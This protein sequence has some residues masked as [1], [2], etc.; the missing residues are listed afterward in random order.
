MPGFYHLSVKIGSRSKGTSAVA[1]AAYR[2]GTKIINLQTGEIADYTRKTGVV[3]SEILI[4]KHA[5]RE[6]FNREILWSAVEKVEERVNSQLFRE[7]TIAFPRELTDEQQ[8]D[9]IRQ[10]AEH[11]VAEG[12]C[13]DFSIHNPDSKNH[14]PHAHMMCTLRKILSDGT[15]A[16]EKTKTQPMYEK[17]KDGNRIP[18]IDEETGKQKIKII[19]NEEHLQWKKVPDIDPKT[20]KQKLRKRKGKG[21][22][23]VWKY[24]TIVYND[25]DFRDKVEEWRKDWADIC[26]EVLDEEHSID[27]RSFA[28]QGI[29]YRIPTIHEGYAARE[30]E[31]KGGIS[32]R[33]ALNRKI[34]A[35]NDEMDEI[36]QAIQEKIKK[37]N[38]LI[39]EAYN[40]LQQRIAKVQEYF[41]RIMRDAAQSESIGRYYESAA[42]RN[43]EIEK[44][45]RGACT[46]VTTAEKDQ[47]E[48][49]VEEQKNK[50]LRESINERLRKLIKRRGTSIDFG[51]TAGR[52][53]GI[54]KTNK[55]K[56]SRKSK[57]TEEFKQVQKK[58]TRE[59]QRKSEFAER[60]RQVQGTDTK[61]ESRKSEFTEGNRQEQ[62]GD[63]KERPREPEADERI[64]R[65]TGNNQSFES[66]RFNTDGTG[67]CREFNERDEGSY[68]GDED[69]DDYGPRPF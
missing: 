52:D 61:E 39:Q 48:I 21:V 15:W 11:R 14:N 60:D 28:R 32:E 57:V 62:R 45:K 49:K 12:M 51:E 19:K 6:Y 46:N 63:T 5:P 27:W 55:R 56:K 54:Q 16:A 29:E 13:V 37:L 64:T 58:D 43:R 20:G 22:E 18:E 1:A 25:W 2:S 23:K 53:R 66:I 40:E 69:S 3:H 59:E 36:M 9:T 65:A 35:A 41:A 42:E 44:E 50:K 26:N 4:P 30:I 24:E 67:E 38:R 33:C 68:D 7:F 47:E 34:R 31:E 8:I 10:F 17:D